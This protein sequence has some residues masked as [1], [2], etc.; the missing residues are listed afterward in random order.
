MHEPAPV[1]F[2]AA[3]GASVRPPLPSDWRRVPVPDAVEPCP[4]CDETT[5]EEI[6]PTDGSRGMHASGDQDMEPTSV[7]VCVACGHEERS[8]AWIMM[9]DDDAVSAEERERRETE[10]QA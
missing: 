5:W 6:T 10:W 1:R 7:I 2:S 4:A 9:G 8:G 3:D